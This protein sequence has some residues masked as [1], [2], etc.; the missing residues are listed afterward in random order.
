MP[1][2]SL[3]K[4]VSAYKNETHATVWEALATILVGLDKL[5]KAIPADHVAAGLEP[6][7]VAFAAKI[8]RPAAEKVGWEAQPDDGHLGKLL[9]V[10][11]VSLMSSFCG[12]DE[13]V[14]AK[15]RSMWDAYM[16]DPSNTEALP[17][18]LKLHV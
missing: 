4:L 13:A 7:F 1:A 17:S 18:D 16:E 8:V 12:S 9:R 15:A 14:S 3:L 11:L 5:F 10:T 2:T 6:A